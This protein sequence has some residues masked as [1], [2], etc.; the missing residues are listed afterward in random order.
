MRR[1]VCEFRWVEIP[2]AQVARLLADQAAELL[3]PAAASAAR[4]GGTATLE[5]EYHGRRVAREVVLDL[6]Q[7]D[8]RGAP[9][10]IVRV[11]V[12]WHAAARPG[13][14]PRMDGQLEAYPIG[15]GVTQLSFQG[16]YRPPLGAVGE[17][18]DSLLLHR[19]AEQ[20]VDRFLRVV[21]QRLRHT[22]LA[23]RAQEET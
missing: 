2:Y 3:R 23:D 7:P 8:V 11:P 14:Y 22:W 10:P 20:S 16:T 18:A 12:S 4:A 6:G 13:L 21:A 19:V 17:A 5:V 15:G 9:F 1:E